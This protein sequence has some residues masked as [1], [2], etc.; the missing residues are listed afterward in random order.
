MILQIFSYT[1]DFKKKWFEYRLRLAIKEANQ[2]AGLF[3]KKYMVVVFSGKP[4]VFQK[5]T[6][7]DLIKR[8]V[9]FKK[10]VKLE[11]IEKRAYYTTK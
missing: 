11:H 4:M 5:T 2:K 3:N 6:L 8:R 9:L 10:G 7:K 1:I